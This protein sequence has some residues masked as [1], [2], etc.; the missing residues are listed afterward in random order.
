MED[1]GLFM[2]SPAYFKIF[3]RLQA[4]FRQLEQILSLIPVPPS[5]EGLFHGT[6]PGGYSGPP[7][8]SDPLAY[9]FPSFS[10][11]VAAVRVGIKRGPKP[12]RSNKTANMESGPEKPYILWFLGLNSILAV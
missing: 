1:T 2:T 8:K 9:V 7:P 6:G 3:Q 10:G 12:G 11:C 5:K 4:R